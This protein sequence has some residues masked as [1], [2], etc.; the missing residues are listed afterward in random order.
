MQ[1]RNHDCLTGRCRAHHVKPSPRV[2]VTITMAGLGREQLLKFVVFP[3]VGMLDGCR[4]QLCQDTSMLAAS[5][6]SDFPSHFFFF[7]V[8]WPKE[9]VRTVTARDW[10]PAPTGSGGFGDWVGNMVDRFPSDQADV[11]PK[12]VTNNCKLSSS[13]R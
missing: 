10:T 11:L 5:E 6:I 2:S 8:T 1:K 9:S 3:D 4:Y 7:S 13:S 12:F